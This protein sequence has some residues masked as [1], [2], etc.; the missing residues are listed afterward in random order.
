MNKK[1]TRLMI[2][3]LLI[4]VLSITSV[5]TVGGYAQTPSIYTFFI[6]KTPVVLFETEEGVVGYVGVDRYKGS[7]VSVKGG[8]YFD[9]Y[10]SNPIEIEKRQAHL[11]VADLSGSVGYVWTQYVFDAAKNAY[12]ILHIKYNNKDVLAAAQRE[13][14]SMQRSLYAVQPIKDETLHEYLYIESG[15]DNINGRVVTNGE[16]EFC[17]VA[18]IPFCQKAWFVAPIKVMPLIGKG[19]T[20]AAGLAIFGNEKQMTRDWKAQSGQSISNIGVSRMQLSIAVVDKQKQVLSVLWSGERNL[21]TYFNPAASS[22]SGVKSITHITGLVGSVFSGP[23]AQITNRTGK[24]INALLPWVENYVGITWKVNENKEINI[25]ANIAF[26]YIPIGTVSD[27]VDW[28]HWVGKNYIPTGS[29]FP[30]YA[31]YTSVAK[32]VYIRVKGTIWIVANASKGETPNTVYGQVH[33]PI[34][35]DITYK[36]VEP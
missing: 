32:P 15:D 24:V 28:Y 17:H 1:Y 29:F 31:S 5:M 2:G 16:G 11:E 12:V 4:S 25:N 30:I 22:Y 19:G 23:L 8:Y 26:S 27:S 10:L 6:G 20:Y 34:P 13:L 3:I 9:L 21:K 18:I 7:V 33:F 14:I 36:V 35:V